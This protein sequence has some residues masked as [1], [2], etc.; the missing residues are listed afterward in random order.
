MALAAAAAEGI[1]NTGGMQYEYEPA[2]RHMNA[3][4]HWWVQAEAM[5]GFLEAYEQS[6]DEKYLQYSQNCWAFVKKYLLDKQYGEW[7]WGV[8]GSLEVMP[9][10]DKAGF[11]KCP[12]HN[13][14]ACLEVVHRI[15][16][17]LKL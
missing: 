15:D 5:V 12:Y 9:G 6:G 11:W 14:R 17:R 7:Y 16:T 10:Q 3:E 4:K 13:S 8:T 1:D 2:T